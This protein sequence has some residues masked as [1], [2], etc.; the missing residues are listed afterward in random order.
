MKF[1]GR[2]GEVELLVFSSLPTSG[3]PYGIPPYL[4]L[5]SVLDYQLLILLFMEVTWLVTC[6][7]VFRFT[8][9]SLKSKNKTLPC[10]GKFL[11][12]KLLILLNL[13][14][15]TYVHICETEMPNTFTTLKTFLYSF[16]VYPSLYT[17]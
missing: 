13:H 10:G 7:T 8:L 2:G 11:D 12:S 6:S 16:T 4:W 9:R 15:L 17:L 3:H 5:S 1:F 14:V